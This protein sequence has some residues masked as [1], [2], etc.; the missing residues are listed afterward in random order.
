MS[1]SSRTRSLIAASLIA[2]ASLTG[3]ALSNSEPAAAVIHE[4]N[5]S[6]ECL[7]HGNKVCGFT[8][9]DDPMLAAAWEEWDAQEGYRSL[10]VDPSRAYEVKVDAYATESLEQTPGSLILVSADGFRFRYVVDYN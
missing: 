6:F 3:C 7:T 1:L 8:D 9:A 10:R 2:G 4:D 5:P